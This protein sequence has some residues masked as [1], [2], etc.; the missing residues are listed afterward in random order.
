MAFLCAGS[1]VLS[2]CCRSCPAVLSI[3][4]VRWLSVSTPFARLAVL[5]YN[6]EKI[7]E[8]ILPSN[9]S[10]CIPFKLSVINHTSFLHWCLSDHQRDEMVQQFKF[11]FC[12]FFCQRFYFVFCLYFLFIYF[13]VQLTPQQS[14]RRQPVIKHISFYSGDYRQQQHNPLTV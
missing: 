1:G 5:H 13:F 7:S 14:S 2:F 11:R 4:T 12:T 3:I 9:P 6:D 8:K 10:P